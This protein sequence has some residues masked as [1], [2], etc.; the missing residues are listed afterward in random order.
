MAC[1]SSSE[2]CGRRVGVVAGG[3]ALSLVRA[4]PAAFPAFGVV[5]VLRLGWGE[6]AR[7]GKGP[8][9]MRPHRPGPSLDPYKRKSV[10]Y[11]FVSC[12]KASFVI[13]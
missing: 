13:T 1:C 2:R 3:E 9:P 7:V 11:F 10:K 5:T 12:M 6:D 8:H 4:T